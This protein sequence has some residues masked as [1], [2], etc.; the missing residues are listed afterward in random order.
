V[1][2]STSRANKGIGNDEFVEVDRSV[3]VDRE[4]VRRKKAMLME[5]D[6]RLEEDL[7]SRRKRKGSEVSSCEGGR[8]E[9]EGGEDELG[10]RLLRAEEKEVSTS[11]PL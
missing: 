11:S 8:E 10:T 5:R 9:N 2:R 7:R 1:T 4:A 3:L 6:K